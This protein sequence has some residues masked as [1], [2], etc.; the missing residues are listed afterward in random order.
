MNSPAKTIA[1]RSILITT[2]FLALSA[3]TYGFGTAIEA[4]ATM[5]ASETLDGGGSNRDSSNRGKRNWNQQYQNNPQ[6]NLVTDIADRYTAITTLI[7]AGK[8]PNKKQI[9]ANI[10]AL[11]INK[12][13]LVA[14]GKNTVAK[15]YVLT[16]WTEY[17][18]NDIKTAQQAAMRVFKTSPENKDVQITQTA[19]SLLAGTKPA[20]PPK[21]KPTPRNNNQNYN[22][23]NDTRQSNRLDLDIESLKNSLI[24]EQATAM[25]LNCLNST[26]FS[27]SP[28]S[29]ILCIIFWKLSDKDAISLA[30]PFGRSSEPNSPA[31]A[32]YDT[33]DNYED[34]YDQE[35]YDYSTDDYG[36]P[37]KGK[38][39]FDS[40]MQA[41]KKIFAKAS[42]NN[43]I[44]LLAAN[45]DK[46]AA[47]QAVINKLLENPWP[48]AHIMAKDPQSQAT[49]LKDVNVT[50]KKPLM[51]IIAPDGEAGKIVYAGPAA[52][53]LAPMMVAKY[54]P[55][56]ATAPTANPLASFLK[57]M[58]KTNTSKRTNN[59]ASHRKPKTPAHQ[60]LSE[61]EKFQAGKLLE[62]AKM[63]IEAGRKLT[64]PKK[65]VELCRQIM[66]DYPDTEY[67]E[68]ARMLLRKVPQRYHARYNI[69][70]EELGL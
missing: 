11:K 60:E 23:Y 63:L 44:K 57:G 65:G 51:V 22:N 25:Q 68:G 36:Q 16:A 47:K 10:K 69:T 8:Q 1:N 26:Y 67:A 6:T 29:D 17:F 27:Y 66:N 30:R 62:N 41:I 59:T 12:S 53:F 15:Y 24:G 33:E 31:M 4:T 5:E 38:A 19:I 64:T 48:W 13:T 40:N 18:N 35:E 9:D 34:E 20:I 49:Q 54:A 46:P 3:I 58:T 2:A 14:L 43:N 37:R 52:G 42:R 70:K 28:A 55:A 21:K 45:T 61:A 39:T 32:R 7:N 50:H 56:S